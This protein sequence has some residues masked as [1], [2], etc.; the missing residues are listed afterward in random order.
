M[1]ANALSAA[2][3][4]DELIARVRHDLD[5][6][7]S[8][9]IQKAAEGLIP[10]E[11]DRQHIFKYLR[12]GELPRRPESV[13]DVLR[14]FVSSALSY[15]TV[16]RV[17][18]A[19][20]GMNPTFQTIGA[21]LSL[22]FNESR[23]DKEASWNLDEMA[24]L[25]HEVAI[26]NG[27]QDSDLGQKT[28]HSR[29]LGVLVDG[30][31]QLSKVTADGLDDFYSDVKQNLASPEAAWAYVEGFSR[32]IRQVGPALTADFFKNIGFHVFVKP[33]FHFLR[34]FPTLTEVDLNLDPK[35]SFISGWHLA[36][37]L[38]MPAFVVDHILYQ[39]GRHGQKTK[40][41]IQSRKTPGTPTTVDS[42]S[43][44]HSTRADNSPGPIPSLP[45]TSEFGRAFESFLKNAQWKEECYKLTVHRQ[46]QLAAVLSKYGGKAIPLSH[47]DRS[48][49]SD[50][51][52]RNAEAYPIICALHAGILLRIE[53]RLEL[54]SGILLGERILP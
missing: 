28:I 23:F 25:A 21:A 8:D 20:I 7:K 44:G 45:L 18:A 31:Q 19:H 52:R 15:A 6:R 32:N 41:K 30:S 14:N 36:V 43:R 42:I 53:D 51:A 17:L 1:I 50:N 16:R 48:L 26:K 40:N 33:D 46:K 9:L 35:E 38:G 49:T 3:N 2:F 29:I 37:K 5:A 22:E 4:D 39:W 13:S 34:Q 54:K 47:F 12:D 11:T 24:T 10:D 27:L